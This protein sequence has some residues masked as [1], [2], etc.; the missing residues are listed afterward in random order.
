MSSDLNDVA[1]QASSVMSEIS[2]S[3]NG[4]E[5]PL[6]DA[7]DDVFKQIQGHINQIHIELRNLCLADDRNED[8]FECL[9]YHESLTEHVNEGC[10]M[11]KSV[12][13]ISKQLLPTKPK[14]WIDPRKAQGTS[15]DENSFKTN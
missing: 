13:K 14:G 15:T 3:Y 10:S 8:Y 9:K 2:V 6:E 12:I 1:S 7:I 5:M 11:F 4:E